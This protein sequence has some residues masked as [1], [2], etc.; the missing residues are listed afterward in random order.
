[1]AKIKIH[2]PECSQ[3]IGID[4]S[5]AGSTGDCPTCGSSLAIPSDPTQ[6]VRILVRRPLP[7]GALLP[8]EENEET[9]RLKKDLAAAHEELTRLR[10]QLEQS[11]HEFE[12]FRITLDGMAEL[13]THLAAERGK[14]A[15]LAKERDAIASQVAETGDLK[16]AGAALTHEVARLQQQ[17][18]TAARERSALQKAARESDERAR[19]A[20]LELDQVN[21]KLDQKGSSLSDAVERM[22]SWER[23][24]AAHRPTVLPDPATLEAL[25]AARADLATS[26]AELAKAKAR[27]AELESALSVV[28]REREEARADLAKHKAAAPDPE[29]LIATQAGLTAAQAKLDNANAALTAARSRMAKLESS[30]SAVTRERDEVRA[31]LAARPAASEPAETASLA[32][33][34]A[35]LTAART[36][37]NDAN[38]ALTAAKSRMAELEAT[39]SALARERDEARTELA[40]RPA[41]VSEPEEAPAVAAAQAEVT[42]ARAEMTETKSRL[43][44]LEASL[45]AITRERDEGRAELARRDAAQREAAATL[46]ALR[47]ESDRS[48]AEAAEAIG[49]RDLVLGSKQSEIELLRRTIG[50]MKGG[51]V[52]DVK[53]EVQIT[54]RLR[55]IERQLGESQESLRAMKNERFKLRERLAKIDS[56]TAAADAAN[57]EELRKQLNE[58]LAR[59]EAVKKY[60]QVLL[61]EQENLKRRLPPKIVD[62]TKPPPESLLD[63]PPAPPSEAPGPPPEAPPPP[64]P[65][66]GTPAESGVAQE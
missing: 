15:A 44:D 25:S 57:G 27:L 51:S 37:L 29:S 18:A 19:A 63:Q 11:T 47:A 40:A 41:A 56:H 58:L 7:P 9:T 2:C 65:S 23:D 17:L 66:A 43:A 48:K 59:D 3:R 22:T 12:R 55:Q 42:A 50:E 28:T 10:T 36:K 52:A 45:S 64:E 62:P 32:A 14:S 16:L 20:H 13:R 53:G 6:P 5:A 34:E 1:M 8:D 54:E 33:S 4:E 21:A 35:E 30:V 24:R 26:H 46:R 61:A 39:V 31:E 60:G 49:R 38:A